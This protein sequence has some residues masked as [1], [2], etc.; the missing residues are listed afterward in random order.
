M[1]EHREINCPICPGPI[2][3]LDGSVAPDYGDKVYVLTYTHKH[4]E[5]HAVHITYEGALKAAYALADERV[6]ESWCDSENEAKFKG[7]E[8]KT[9]ALAFFHDIENETSYGEIL[10][11]YETP[12]RD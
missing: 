12:L 4:G 2:C 1:S 8:D 5:D 9:A 10:E 6:D 3:K 7:I 11:I